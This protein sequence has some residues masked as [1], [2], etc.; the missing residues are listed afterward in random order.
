[1]HILAQLLEYHE[2]VRLNIEK[3]PGTILDYCSREDIGLKLIAE[4]MIRARRHGLCSLFIPCSSTF[5][6]FLSCNTRHKR[7]FTIG[8]KLDCLVEEGCLLLCMQTEFDLD[9]NNFLVLKI[10]ELGTT[11]GLYVVYEHKRQPYA[12]TNIVL[13]YRMGIEDDMMRLSTVIVGELSS[14]QKRTAPSVFGALN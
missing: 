5:S 14:M 7:S 9:K 1:M 12:I 10:D 6:F 3:P 8:N 13:D 2:T 11:I 4:I